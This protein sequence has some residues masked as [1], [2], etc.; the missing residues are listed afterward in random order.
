MAGAEPI[1]V[2]L[3]ATQYVILSE[4]QR[5]K[6]ALA[7]TKDACNQLLADNQALL[8]QLEDAN[9]ESYHVSEHFRQEILG[10]NQKIADLQSQ[11]QQLRAEKDEHI[12]RLQEQAAAREEQLL[13]EAEATSSELMTRID[14]LQAELDSVADFKQNKAEA[15][16][17][18]AALREENVALRETLEAQRTQLERHYAG[19]HAKM[20]K[21][22]EQKLEELK[23]SQEEELEERLDAGVKRILAAN[24]RMAEEM[25]LHVTV[26]NSTNTTECICVL[27]AVRIVSKWCLLQVVFSL[28]TVGVCLHSAMQLAVALLE[29]I[30][31]SVAVMYG[32]QE[33]DALQSEVKLLQVDRARLAREVSLKQQLE[34]GWA[35]RAGQQAATLKE[36]QLKI[37]TLEKSLQQVMAD[38]AAER[39]GVVARA[40]AQVTASSSEVDALRRLLRLK[41]RE[42]Q[43]LRRL[44]Q[45]VLLQRTEVEIFLL[46]SLHQVRLAIEKERAH[47]AIAKQLDQNNN[48]SKTA[49]EAASTAFDGCS[50]KPG[51]QPTAAPVAGSMDIRDLSWEDRERVLR[52]L[53]AKLSG[54]TVDQRELPQHPLDILGSTGQSIPSAAADD[55]AG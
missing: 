14:N 26:S 11:L 35:Q 53:F 8:K 17:Q 18:L 34:E 22:Y 38:F 39:A 36:A 37:S 20:R 41:G 54:R 9:K 1:T 23:R 15:E 27:C 19:L 30:P 25:R 52:L 29:L 32:V 7:D 50:S 3:T 47:A 49:M 10:K 21:E 46:S 33:S 55:D 31:D 24:R 48:T 28:Q 5:K 51:Q 12:S 13:S 44:G 40:Q 42:L 16:A 4:N 45:E 43:Q 2:D 6:K